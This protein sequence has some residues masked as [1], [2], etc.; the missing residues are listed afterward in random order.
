MTHATEHDLVACRTLLRGG[1]RSFYVASFALP[2]DVRAS[3]T[4]LYAFC[5]MADDAIDLGSDRNA[6]LHEWR[7]RLARLYEGTPIDHPV[8]R[9]F[10][11]VIA[12]FSIPR[13]LPEALLE[14]F[15][16][17]AQGAR[18]D[19]LVELYAY[20]ARVAGSVGAMMAMLMGVRDANAIARACDLGVAMQ[21]TNIARDVGEDA[22]AG[23]LY[24]PMRWMRA[25]GIDPHIWLAQPRHTDA[26]AGVVARL[27]RA[28]DR[29]YDRARTG[30][31]A[32][33]PACRPG[34]EA[35]RRIYAEIGREVERTQLDAV[36]R[37]AVVRKRTQL[38]LFAHAWVAR[39]S[40]S[41]P[42]SRAVPLAA[43]QF[44]VE[45][46]SRVSAHDHRRPTVQR[47]TGVIDAR[48]EW[49]VALF[50]RLEREQ[51]VSR[52]RNA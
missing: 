2:R 32:L 44:L 42:A 50:D 8:D 31:A 45:A 18:Y 34:I 5:R 9:A 14:G 13:A 19:T 28:A 49:L 27:L 41:G 39:P 23:R 7:D 11:D 22:R 40:L 1:S 51:S 4:A 15:A 52:V 25:A 24:L 20:A 29:L 33:P 46:V 17:D 37:R 16:W 30:V 43:T 48:V 10:A 12:K 36:S 21:L 26:L 3:A 6:A 47:P 38:R 35:A